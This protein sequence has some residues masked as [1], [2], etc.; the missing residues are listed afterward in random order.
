MFVT[1]VPTIS[2][3]F[4]PS[5][6]PF[7]SI[8]SARPT[9]TG[10]V[11]SV[12]ISGS[13]EE[14]LSEEDASEIALAIAKIYGVEEEDVVMSVEYVSSGTLNVTI[15]EELSEADATAVLEESISNT[16]GIHS[17]EVEVTIH[18]DGVVTYTITGESY[19]EVE[20]LSETT[21]KPTFVSELD[22]LLS[23]GES[24][25]SVESGT[26]S[27]EVEVLITG[28]C[29]VVAFIKYIS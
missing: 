1:S 9:I 13:V 26:S 24:G 15:P 12:S 17:S 3:I 8:P 19:T 22:S 2:P 21:S 14:A 18:D 29:F 6:A 4:N 25:I 7:T 5:S 16:L 27:E 23:G 10:E 11:A 28:I 20:T